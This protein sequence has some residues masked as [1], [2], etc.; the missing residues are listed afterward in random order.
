M[1]QPINP[2]DYIS[3]HADFIHRGVF[4][5]QAVYEQELSHI[6]ARNWLYLCH[7]TQLPDAGDYITTYM[8]E[9]PVIVARAGNGKLYA[10][11]NSCRH[12]GLPVCRTDAGNAKR[13]ICPYHAWSYAISGELLAM[14]QERHLSSAPDKQTLG[15]SRV[16]RLESYRGLIFG[17]FNPHIE[18]LD[19]YLGEQKFYLDT[20]FDRF[21]G[22][23][24][25]LGQ[26]HKWALRAN[27]KLPVENQLG[28]VAHGPLLHATVIEKGSQPVQEIDNFGLNCVVK[29]GH[30]AAIR[31]MPADADPASIAWG[32]EGMAA[33][34]GNQEFMRY[35][36]DVQA[37]AASRIGELRARIKG[38]TYGVYPNLSFLW[39]NS[40]LRVTHP[41]GPGHIEY[42][43]WWV[44]P[45]AAPDEVKQLLR[46]NYNLQFGPAGMLEE[47]DSEAWTQQYLGSRIPDARNERYYYGLGLGEDA[48]HPELPGKVGSCYNEHYARGFYQRWKQDMSGR[49]GS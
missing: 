48:K 40:T 3:E 41:K 8:G 46:S 34:L 44:V 39:S 35:L 38:L 26:A 23:V 1:I 10:S 27:W 17:S 16:P 20:Y 31:L 2:D 32:L 21:E 29:N 43:S 28:D 18:S 12:R 22:G 25:V 45:K 30:G 9:T 6:F 42:W 14:P 7:E 4:C 11:I 15:L 33:L 19:D 5:D 24:E 47:E 36:L 49:P 37:Q 13:F